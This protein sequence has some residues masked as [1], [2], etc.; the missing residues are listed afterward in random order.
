MDISSAKISKVI[1]HRVGNKLR[2]EGIH[3]SP[4]E[5]Q[6]SGALDDLLLRNLLAPVVRNGQE[7]YLTH[8]SDIS[9]N[10]INHYAVNG[11]CC[12]NAGRS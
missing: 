3:L 6:R 1:V 12:T 11:R 9:L 8:E 10:T 7:Y 2:D 4:I 5:C